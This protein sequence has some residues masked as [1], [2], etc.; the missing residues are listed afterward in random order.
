MLSCK[1]ILY[2]YFKNGYNHYSDTSYS[3]D[4]NSFSGLLL[5][6]NINSDDKNVK[7]RKEHREKC[8]TYRKYSELAPTI[9][10]CYDNYGYEFIIIY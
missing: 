3:P 6:N 10:A 4:S 2:Y 5:S 9:S 1:I 8:K 7:D